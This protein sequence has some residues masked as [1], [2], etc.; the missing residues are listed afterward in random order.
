MKISSEHL[1]GRECEADGII[2]E[3]R[4]VEGTNP[5]DCN[6]KIYREGHIPLC[7]HVCS[8]NLL[9]DRGGCNSRVWSS[10]DMDSC[11]NDS[12]LL[13]DGMYY[14]A[15]HAKELIRKYHKHNAVFKQMVKL[16]TEKS[17]E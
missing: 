9:A 15:E 11:G 16:A 8:V 3:I 5:N 10:G 2:Y 1:I 14:C 4:G 6:V 17:C 7:R 13:V 12:V